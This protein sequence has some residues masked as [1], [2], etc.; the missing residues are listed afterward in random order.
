MH[1]QS[2]VVPLQADHFLF[3]GLHTVLLS[4]ACVRACVL[5]VRVCIVRVYMYVHVCVCVCVH[6]CIVRVYMYVHVCVCV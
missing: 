2:R 4:A 1:N 5:H 6:V 3:R